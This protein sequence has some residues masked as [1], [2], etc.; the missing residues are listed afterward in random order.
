M[1]RIPSN[2]ISS[3]FGLALSAPFAGGLKRYGVFELFALKKL[4]RLPDFEPRS[5]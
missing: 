4:N 5:I 3:F 2:H 1:K